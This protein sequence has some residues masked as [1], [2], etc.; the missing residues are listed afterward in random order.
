MGV[1][2]GPAA[3]TS[4]LW[5]SPSSSGA[6]RLLPVRLV[7]VGVEVVGDARSVGD[8]RVEGDAEEAEEPPPL[9]RP[10]CCGCTTLRSRLVGF[11]LGFFSS[12]KN[13][14]HVSTQRKLPL[15]KDM[16]VDNTIAAFS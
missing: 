6:M 3:A 12:S 8:P 11:R 4:P 7:P 5:G 14:S 16:L 13:A 2:A 10:V 15:G 9:D 1:D